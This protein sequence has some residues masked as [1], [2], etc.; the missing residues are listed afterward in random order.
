MQSLIRPTWTMQADL[1]AS[2]RELANFM[3]NLAVFFLTFKKIF[4]SIVKNMLN[5]R[6]YVSMYRADHPKEQL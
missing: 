4:D 3:I 6:N 2:I 1:H 5:K